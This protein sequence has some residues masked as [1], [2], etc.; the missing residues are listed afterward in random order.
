MKIVHVVPQVAREAAGPSYS[1]PRLCQALA[2]CGNDVELKCIAASGPIPGVR[3]STYP[4]WP[5]LKRF[6]VSTALAR[7][8][9]PA[10]RS[11]DII[12]NHSLWSMVNVAAGCVVPGHYA[13]LV[14]SPRGTLSSWALE[15]S[16][17]RKQL[18]WPLQKRALTRADLL[19]ATSDIE[20]G[21]I[22]ALGLRA[23]VAVIP[24]GIDLPPPPSAK[25]GTATR[26]VLFLSRIHPKKGIDNLLH[27]WQGLETR[28]PG[29]RLVIAG[30]GEPQH[31]ADVRALAKTLKVQRVEF[32]GPLYGDAKH[33]AYY[34]ADLFV[35]PTHSENFGM[36]IAEALAHGCP[37]IV[38]RGAPWQ[39]L[40][41]ERCGWWIDDDADALQHTLDAAMTLPVDELERMGTR[42]R[43]WMARDFSW[44]SIGVAM[45]AAYQWLM[46][47]GAP[48]TFVQRN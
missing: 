41:T 27:A 18:L 22:R 30:T 14:T 19:H 9:R 13:K 40:E 5:V 17:R 29:W 2:E 28:H 7:S 35:L 36:V 44:R 3:L 37:A 4:D 6:E 21:E 8:L 1:V 12:H 48:P 20:Y 47:G 11:V 33:A 16:Q 45:D 25:R 26:T 39:G 24:N 34:D 23:P 15:R 43:D 38:T 42:G 10:A 31:I 46:T 32:P